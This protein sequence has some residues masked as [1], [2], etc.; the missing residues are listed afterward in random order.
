MDNCTIICYYIFMETTDNGEIYPSPNAQLL[1]AQQIE[2]LSEPGYGVVP[3]AGIPR[4]NSF[5]EWVQSG[6]LRTKNNFCFNFSSVFFAEFIRQSE[7]F[8]RFRIVHANQFEVLQAESDALRERPHYLDD[9]I[10]YE[11]EY[12]FWD[13][14]EKLATLVDVNDKLVRSVDDFENS[15]DARDYL[16]R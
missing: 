7:H 11:V 9:D 16:T 2:A 3:P 14:H 10:P 15:Y 13:A 6:G 12:L 8:E 5:E 1:S 4:Y